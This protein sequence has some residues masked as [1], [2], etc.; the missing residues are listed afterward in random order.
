VVLPSLGGHAWADADLPVSP[1]RFETVVTAPSPEIATPHADQLASS[2]VVSPGDSP[3][4]HDDLGTLML[5]VPGVTTIRT[6]A[7]G[8]SMALS[9][10]GSNA[11]QVRVYI[12]GVPVAIAEGGG[13]DLSTLPLGDV[14]LVEVYRGQAPLMFGESALGGILAITTR[15]PGTPSV[16]ARAGLESYGAYFG[17]AD[18]SGRAGR[19]RLYLGVHA[20]SSKGDFPYPNDNGTPL[21]SDDDRTVPRQNADVQQVDGTFRAAVDLRGRRTLSLG[22]IAFGREQGLPGPHL[23]Q[24]RFV[25]FE[26]SRAIAYLRYESRDDLGPSGRLAA[27][28]YFSA[29]RDHY[30]DPGEIS[31]GAWDTHDTTLS[32]GFTTNATRPL[33][34]WLRLAAVAEARVE[35]FQPVNDGD[36]E[37]PVGAP[38][39]RLVAVGGVEATF[40]WRRADLDVVPSVRI[41]QVQDVVTG[42]DPF[43]QTAR[44]ASPPTT[45][46][47]P[48]VRFAA[49]RPFG[50]HVTLKANAGRYARTPSFLELYAGAGRLLGNPA[51]T[52][53]WGTNGDVS[54]LIDGG[55]RVRVSSRTAVFGAVV[56]DL[57]E[58]QHNS[59]GQSRPLNVGSARIVGVE[60]EVRL[61]VGHWGRFVGQG[62][63]L[64]ARDESDN[65]AHHGRQLPLRPR[66]QAYARPELVNVPLRRGG[67]DGP[68]GLGPLDV[69][70]FVDG[71]LFAG[72]YDDPTNLFKLPSR[73]LVG[74]G[75]SV[76]AP[77]FGLRLTCSAQN[78]TNTPV[79]DMAYWP[80]PGRTISFALA[81]R[82][83]LGH[84]EIATNSN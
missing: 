54:L 26:T 74:A 34:D 8:S 82:S 22:V 25:R 18:A 76:G 53:E 12:D 61:A 79:W 48:I 81:W 31:A 15:T 9:L 5:E 21:N 66:W 41:E 23:A 30:T 13:V 19:L 73:V 17:D 70:A 50:P 68:G 64:D 45:R 78:L 7:L 10:R 77:R 14:D 35:T 75:I 3:R 44:P 84:S 47:L 2:S 67:G 51:L 69:G 63:F 46:T 60:E 59:Y 24:T 83:A 20:L 29:Q 65:A 11:D 52:P 27:Q 16:G 43:F 33:A 49:L 6:G 39:R 80:L 38:A 1:R 56:N 37:M 42:R 62:T 40:Q 72:S 57:I 55:T 32:T 36:D 4:A 28:L 58:W 71:A